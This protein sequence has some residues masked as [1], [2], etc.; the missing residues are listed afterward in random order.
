MDTAKLQS[1]TADS[2]KQLRV[3]PH[4]F[5]S[6]L[7]PRSAQQQS[8]STALRGSRFNFEPKGAKLCIRSLALLC[9]FAP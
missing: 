7:R 6:N 3:V 9:H 1:Q 5:F 2:T 4:G 8:L